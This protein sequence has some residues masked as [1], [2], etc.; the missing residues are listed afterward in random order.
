M[1]LWTEIRSRVLTEEIY[2]RQACREYD[3]YWCGTRL[4]TPD[5]RNVAAE[6][7]A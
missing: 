1:E 7:Q 2:E 6:G 4:W 3:L 5:Y